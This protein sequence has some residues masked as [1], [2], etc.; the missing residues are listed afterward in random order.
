MGTAPELLSFPSGMAFDSEG[1]L[2]VTDTN[3]HRVQ[4]FLP[5]ETRGATV[6]GSATGEPGTGIDQLNMPTGICMDQR[7]GSLL[8]ADRMNGRVLRFP[9]G[10]A[11]KGE[12]VAGADLELSRPWGVCQDGEGAIYV[13]DERRALVLKVE[14]PPPLLSSSKT[15]G[16]PIQAR[17]TQPKAQLSPPS[18]SPPALPEKEVQPTAG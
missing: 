3:N 2:Y 12:V 6:A 10:G 15:G 11:Q 17:A 5:G 9:A 8:V 13:S 14:A 4:C 16:Y 1:R 7:D 18:A